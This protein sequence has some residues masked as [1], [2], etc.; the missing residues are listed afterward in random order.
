MKPGRKRKQ[1]ITLATV[2]DRRSSDLVRNADVAPL[3]ID[4]PWAIEP[5]E[6]IVAF[7]SLRDDS[8]ARMHANHL[9]DDAQYEAGRAWQADYEVIEIGGA[10]A[11]DPT[12]EAVDGGKPPEMFTDRKRKAARNLALAAEQLGRLQEGILRDVLTRR[13]FPSDVAKTR[14]FTSERHVAHFAWLFRCSLDTLAE[15]YGFSTCSR[16]PTIY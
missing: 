13:M 12:K 3:E 9:V 5:G 6:K 16:K 15:V 4:D 10:S 2:H 11:I 1:S 14:G 8:L 7:R